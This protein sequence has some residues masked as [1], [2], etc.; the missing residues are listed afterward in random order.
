MGKNTAKLFNSIPKP[1]EATSVATSI[2]FFPV[3][4]SKII[5]NT[6]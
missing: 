2:G 3:L 5:I 6:H 1:L 4:N